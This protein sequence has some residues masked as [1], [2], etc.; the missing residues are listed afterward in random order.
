MKWFWR[1]LYKARY[2]DYCFIHEQAYE[3]YCFLCLEK[4]VKE[5]KEKWFSRA[6]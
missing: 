2:D 1:L 6:R 3:D 5:K 4:R